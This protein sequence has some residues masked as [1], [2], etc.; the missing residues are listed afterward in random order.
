[1]NNTRAE[2]ANILTQVI[3]RGRSLT[4][5]LDDGLPLIARHDD[6]AFVQALCYGVLRWYFR[7]DR[8]LGFLTRKPIKDEAVRMLALIGLYQLGY[9]RVKPHAAVSET[10]AAAGGKRWAKPLLNGILRTYQRQQA[11]LDSQ[12]D[13]DDS[14]ATAH[15]RWLLKRLRKDWPDDYRVLLAHNNESPPMVLRINRQNIHREAYLEKL[16]LAKKPAQTSAFCPDA[17]ILDD[18]CPVESLPGFRE[19][20]VSVQDTAAQLAAL[21]LDAQPGMRVLDLCAAPGGKTIHILEACSGLEDIVAVDIGPERMQ[22]VRDNLARSGFEATLITADASDPDSWWDRQPFD[23]IL[24]DAPCSATGVIRR[25]PDIK[26]LR[27]PADIDEL[28][29]TQRR[30][31]EAAWLMLAP[32]GVLLYATCSVLRAENE[33]T[34]S[35][36]LNQHADAQELPINADWGISVPYGRQILTGMQGMDGFYYARLEKARA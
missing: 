21:L 11:E 33:D 34:I 14:S 20:D 26:L 22:R 36:F 23:R 15:P 19:G 8:I 4:A 27:Q 10:V 6:R 3:D 30:I 35:A 16:T 32:G 25:H 1:M 24:L 17:L 5:A 2:A 9:L 28:C 18:P 13:A 7:L 31:L 29:V 12:A